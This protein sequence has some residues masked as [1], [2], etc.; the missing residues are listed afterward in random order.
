MFLIMRLAALRVTCLGI[1]DTFL[2]VIQ[3]DKV[4]KTS[5]NIGDKSSD[6]TYRPILSAGAYC[7]SRVY[8]RI[9]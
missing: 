3:S 4:G 9:S 8:C 6:V 1:D 5:I 2:T 7:K